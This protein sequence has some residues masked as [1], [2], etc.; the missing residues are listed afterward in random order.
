MSRAR[1]FH[2]APSDGPGRLKDNAAGN[3][4]SEPSDGRSFGSE[5]STAGSRQNG[6]LLLACQVVRFYE[7][8]KCPLPFGC[9]TAITWAGD[10]ALP[11]SNSSI[12]PGAGMA[13]AALSP[14]AVRGW[15]TISRF[16]KEVKRMRAQDSMSCFAHK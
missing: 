1:R 5:V 9:H 11:G 3:W 12:D 8:V 13:G 4:R 10:T 7:Q 14:N 6:I 2:R 16:L 15:G